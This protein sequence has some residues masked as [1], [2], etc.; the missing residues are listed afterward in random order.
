MGQENM[1]KAGKHFIL[2]R[3]AGLL[4]WRQDGHEQTL[5]DMPLSLMTCGCGEVLPWKSSMCFVPVYISAGTFVYHFAWHGGDM[6]GLYWR[7]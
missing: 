1:D 2:L 6:A 3:P 4:A 5:T 7:A